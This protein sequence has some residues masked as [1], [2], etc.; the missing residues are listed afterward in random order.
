[1]P[2]QQGN[3]INSK[4][5]AKIHKG[6]TKEQLTAAIGAP[7]LITPFKSN[8]LIYVYTLRPTEGKRRYRRLEVTLADGRVTNYTVYTQEN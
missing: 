5:I 1:M 7:I 6:M 3:I 4:L 2:I 8:Q